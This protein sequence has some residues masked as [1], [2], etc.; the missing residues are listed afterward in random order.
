MHPILFSIPLPGWTIPLF[1]ALLVLAALGVVLAL[2]GYRKRA[3]D[4]L[5]IG[6]AA[7]IGGAIAG[8]SFRGEVYT[9][10]P[11]PVYSYGAMLCLSIIV[12]WYL[13]LG[14]A[15][16]DGL[17]REVMANCYFVT[18]VAALVGARLL[19][20]VTNPDEFSAFRD[21]FALRRG[22]LVAYGGFLGG[23]L[24]S[25][26]FLYRH[27]IRLLPWADVAVPSLASGL[28]ITR[29]GCYLYGC[30]FG[31]PLSDTAPA[32]LKSLGTFPKWAE[33]T[34]LEGNGS[35]A[36][37][38]HV[39]QRGLSPDTTASLPVHPTQLYEVLTGL[40]LLA[41][42]FL[43]RRRQKFRGQVFLAFTLGYGLLRFG[44]ETLRDD[45]ERGSYGPHLS[46]HVILPAAAL[47][48]GL[49]FAFGPARSVVDDKLRRGMQAI[50]LLPGPALYFLLR[51]ASFAQGEA[52]QLS[53][54]QWIG[55][56]TGVAAALVWG[57]LWEAAKKN[58]EAAMAL[59]PG[60]VLDDEEDED[61][62]DPA[63]DDDGP[64]HEADESRAANE[65]KP[66]TT[67]PKAKKKTTKAKP[68]TEAESTA[69]KSTATKA[70]TATESLEAK[71]KTE[72]RSKTASKPKSKSEKSAATPKS[73][74]SADPASGT[75]KAKPANRK[76]KK[77]KKRKAIAPTP[78]GETS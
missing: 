52:I 23:F 73:S 66:A 18:A 6:V 70:K 41:L 55:L 39:N 50:A 33:G 22:G 25:W 48:F 65:R 44:L 45:I 46:A 51:P 63:L 34:V 27:R 10:S 68:K 42:V 37:I 5:V 26:G 30:D 8:F 14:L 19:Y 12:G 53:T 72:A 13:T 57:T 1:P 16:K 2:F 77:K 49:A 38:Q 21:L 69:T 29:L 74:S 56:G 67:K 28:V 11:L 78:A 62:F 60:A 61:E 64:A 35:P 75:A 43:V 36:W 7:A 47:A 58:P 17:P 40:T 24:G 20:V 3:T 15:S 76:S 4:L 31:K 59:G 9:L 54:S 32:W 71:S